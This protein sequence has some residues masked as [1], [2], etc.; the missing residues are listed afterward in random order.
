MQ[1]T[2]K[3]ISYQKNIKWLEVAIGL[4]AVGMAFMIASIIIDFVEG[5]KPELIVVS[6][7][8]VATCGTSM[9]LLCH[10]VVKR[11]SVVRLCTSYMRVLSKKP[12]NAVDEIYESKGTPKEEVIRNFEYLV[13]LGFLEGVYIDKEAQVVNMGEDA[14]THDFVCPIC[15]GTTTV[16]DGQE[17]KCAFCGS[18]KENDEKKESEVKD[19]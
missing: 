4:C 16:E 3:F 2:S 8:S 9:T 10:M 19:E 18:I 15:S 12:H 11:K 6:L 13:S 5:N 1:E 17:D 7:C 14:S